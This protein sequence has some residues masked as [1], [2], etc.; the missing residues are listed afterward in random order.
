MKKC[1][2][3][4]NT[5]MIEGRCVTRRAYII[6]AK[7]EREYPRTYDITQEN[8]CNLTCCPECH[9]DDFCHFEGCSI[10]AMLDG[11]KKKKKA[12]K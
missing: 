6:L 5:C 12:K 1:I 9:L 7:L 3:D 8:C 10:G 4:C 2:T 11:M